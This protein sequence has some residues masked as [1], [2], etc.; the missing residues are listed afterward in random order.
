MLTRLSSQQPPWQTDEPSFRITA[1][2]LNPPSCPHPISSSVIAHMPTSLSARDACTGH[3][4][5]GTTTQ[6]PRHEDHLFA[7]YSEKNPK[8]SNHKTKEEKRNWAY[9]EGKNGS[10]SMASCL[11]SIINLSRNPNPIY[12]AGAKGEFITLDTFDYYFYFRELG[13]MA[14]GRWRY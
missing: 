3:Q 14:G 8:Q 6:S 12:K 13:A 1:S 7:V 2:A 9:K 5:G 11:K 4:K 10:L